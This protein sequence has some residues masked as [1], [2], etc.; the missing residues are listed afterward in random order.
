M[1][2]AICQPSLPTTTICPITQGLINF[3]RARACVERPWCHISAPAADLQSTYRVPVLVK[4]IGW[5]RFC[6]N[7]PTLSLGSM[8]WVRNGRLQGLRELRVSIPTV[9]L[10]FFL[11]SLSFSAS[12][13]SLAWH[14]L[15]EGGQEGESENQPRERQCRFFAIKRV[16]N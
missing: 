8:T 14:P 2:V 10:S 15:R 13:T 4:H 16:W 3:K 7:V 1:A 6:S 5:K 9:L 12:P 11:L